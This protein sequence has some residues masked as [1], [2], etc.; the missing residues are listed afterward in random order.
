MDPE[1]DCRCIAE[2]D[3]TGKESTADVISRQAATHRAVMDLDTS[4]DA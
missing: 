1:T 2:H 3:D 4:T